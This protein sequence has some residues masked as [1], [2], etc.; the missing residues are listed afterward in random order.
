MSMALL[1]ASSR[2]MALAVSARCLRKSCPPGIRT[3]DTGGYIKSRNA[4]H[5]IAAPEDRKE[6]R[7]TCRTQKHASGDSIAAALR[8][9][10]SM[11]HIL[12][13]NINALTGKLRASVEIPHPERI[14]GAKRE[15]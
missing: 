4:S 2:A 8:V 5:A 1:T 12:S 3:R 13:N 6:A 15:G 11:P 7:A 10:V 9:R 14:E